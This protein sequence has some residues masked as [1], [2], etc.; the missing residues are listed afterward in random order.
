MT[1]VC[2]LRRPMSYPNL[3]WIGSSGSPGDVEEPVA[4][5]DDPEPTVNVFLES[6]TRGE[7]LELLADHIR[8]SRRPG[9][10]WETGSSR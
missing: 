4:V 2:R 10:G 7:C 1:G 3:P 8:G 5:S 9:R 6:L